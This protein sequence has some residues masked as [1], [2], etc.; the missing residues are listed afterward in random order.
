MPLG[1]LFYRALLR[2]R[3]DKNERPNLQGTV[4]VVAGQEYLDTP[5]QAAP[6]AVVEAVVA[7][8]VVAEVQVVVVVVEAEPVG[9]LEDV[10]EQQL[11]WYHLFFMK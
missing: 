4:L 6:V 3:D 11:A 8:V 5:N 10:Q 9:F 1:Q 7:A 2:A